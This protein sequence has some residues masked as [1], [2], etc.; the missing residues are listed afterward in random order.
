MVV[1]SAAL[2]MLDTN[3]TGY[4]VNGRSQA[5][6]THFK[7]AMAKDQVTISTIT[8][9]EILHGL[10]RRPEA[11]RLRSSVLAL[12]ATVQ[13][14]P[15]NS[16]AAK[17]YAKLRT[18]LSTKGES[19]SLIDLLIASHALAIGAILVSHDQ[20]FQHLTAYIPVVDW[21]TDL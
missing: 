20:A 4:L 5:V 6:R 17:S 7:Q 21:A 13:I 19:L 18:T 8:E 14:R 3:I 1:T 16:D 2:Y 12:L 11:T 10:E 15:W 9:A